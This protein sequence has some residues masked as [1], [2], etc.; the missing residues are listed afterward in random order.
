MYRRT[1]LAAAGLIAT[2]RLALADE[3]RILRF[4]PYADVAII[5]PIWSTNYAT[6]THA[7][8][9]FETLYGVDE[10]L[11]PQ[12]QMVAG[13][14]VEED[15]K[16]WRLTLRDGLRFHDGTPVLARD[17]VASLNRWAKRDGFGQAL[18][19]ATDELAATDDRTIE[20]RLKRPFPL[21][22]AALARPSALVPVIMPER[23]AS[24][25]AFTQVPEA[26]GSGP[27]R[28][29]PQERVP[30]ARLA[31][32]RHEA[33]VPRP[34]GVP[35]MTAGPRIAHLDRIEFQVI[36]DPATAAAALQAGSVDWVE[37]PLIDLLPVLRR[38]RDIAVEVK[39][40]WGLV[41]HLRFNHLHP[42]FDNPAIRRVLLQAISQ[43]DCM[44]AVAG[45]EPS[46]WRADVGVFPPGTAMASEAGLDHLKRKPDLP[47]LRRAL[48]QAGYKGERVVMLAGTDVPRIN[49]VSEVTAE[50]MRQLGINL[51]YVATDWGTANQRFPVRRPPAE[52]GWNCYCIYSSGFDLM[53]PA[54]FTALR[55][56]GLRAGIGWPDIPRMEELRQAWL[57]AP[58]ESAQ[59]AVARDIQVLAME[60]AMF[61]PLGLFAQPVAYRKT[62]VGMPKGPPLFTGIRKTG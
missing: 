5:D 57:D 29:L 24:L 52:G 38:S 39:D 56:N 31:Y 51:D 50:V 20:F 17:C 58:D 36:P 28:F 53:N 60:Q 32:A 46:L 34:D 12:P 9:V 61:V 15:G 42:P 59:K 16:R 41:G 45:Q 22:P 55:A 47:A 49:A 8:L 19:A 11:A 44:E 37:Q 40:P 10:S 48:Q 21:L 3:T 23:L 25:D 2:P 54:V 7:H 13:H 14:A 4:V 27:W 6:R 26:I 43:H 33:Y 18:M 62:L 35:G 30:G 1:L